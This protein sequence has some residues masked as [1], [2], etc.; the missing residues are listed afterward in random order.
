[1]AGVRP[2]LCARVS[3]FLL[4][5]VSVEF[6]RDTLQNKMEGRNFTKRKVGRINCQTLS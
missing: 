3:I 5:G 6:E 4:C 1:V 2:S